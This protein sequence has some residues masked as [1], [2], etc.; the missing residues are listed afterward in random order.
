MNDHTTDIH[1]ISNTFCCSV[2]IF[3]VP[4]RLGKSW[5][6]LGSDVDGSFWLQ[7]DMFLQKKI[8]VAG[9]VASRYVFW[10]AGMPK[11]L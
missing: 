5:N 7:I 2:F 3:W 8:H 11:M 1:R 9:I 4:M 10:A 6:L